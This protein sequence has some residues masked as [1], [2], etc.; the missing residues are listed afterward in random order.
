LGKSQSGSFE[1]ESG[2]RAREPSAA[3]KAVAQAHGNLDLN[4]TNGTYRS[5]F[6][7]T[8]NDDFDASGDEEDASADASA[9]G[10][11]R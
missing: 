5:D 4:A 11:G 1:S 10:A 2:S 3:I 7:N 8:Y 9:S 6:E